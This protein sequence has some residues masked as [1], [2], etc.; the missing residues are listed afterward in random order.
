MPRQL[1]NL[2][3][4]EVSS[5]DRGAGEGVQILLMKRHA[6]ENADDVV[7]DLAKLR[8]L[9][10]DNGSLPQVDKAIA[11]L[12]A[13]IE[14]INK[15]AAVT[16]KDAA[17]TETV[18]QFNDHIAGLAPGHQESDMKPEEIAKLVTDTVTKAVTDATKDSNAKVA[19][20]ELDLAVERLPADH[21][22]FCKAMS[23]EDKKKFAAK[24]KDE[25]DGEVA[26]AK[27]KAAGDPIVKGLQ[28]EVESLTKRLAASDARDAVA[29]F[30]KK[31]KDLGLPEAHGEIMRKAYAG[32]AES[33]TKHEA[34]LKGLVEQ[35]R[36]GK[37]FAE[38]GSKEADT[39]ASAFQKFEGLAA[40]L[41]K[42]ETTLTKE[43][44]FDKV[45]NDPANIALR[46]VHKS[47]E[48]R[49]RQ[50]AA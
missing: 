45:Y 35:V 32:D 37:V 44:A 24:T 23:D 46:E 11:A 49:K 30:A 40:E 25:R 9:G 3:I 6:V 14:S 28:T 13:S 10:Q 27:K 33:I 12:R 5:V 48:I 38:F 39:G 36:T 8:K 17:I 22:E 1:K 7:I 18:K 2:V 47:E 19:K 42:V 34:V 15:D 26:D 43:Q 16:D 31:A 29:S 21:R 50:V 20:L 41:R 4:D